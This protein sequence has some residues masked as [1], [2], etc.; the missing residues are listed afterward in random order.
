MDGVHEAEPGPE[1]GVT[2]PP[3]NHGGS[4]P[5]GLAHV[6]QSSVDRGRYG[7]MFRQLAPFAPRDA[8]LK[9]LADSM[10]PYPQPTAGEPEPAEATAGAVQPGENPD[11]PA[12]YTYLGQF[13]DHDITFD[14][15]SVLQRRNDP[16]AL[17]NYRTPRFDLDLIYGSG[18]NDQ[19]FLYDQA[20]PHK[21]LI[22]HNLDPAQE[23]VDLPRNAQGRALLGDPRNDVH[24]IISQLTLA[25]LHFHNAVVDHLR[26]RKVPD[27]DL[28]AEAQRITRWHY[29]WV[30]TEDYLQRTVGPE[31]LRRVL[32][33]DPAGGGRRAELRY[34]KWKNDPF[35]PVEFSA[36]AYRFGHSQVRST[37][38]LNENQP[39]KHILLPMLDADPLD[40][41]EGF[42]P[43]P[44]G[45]T[46]GWD[47]YFEIDG[48]QPQLSRRIDTKM[49]GPFN[50]LPPALDA[51]GRS[52]AF[53]DMVRGRALGLPSGQDVAAAM[54]L[55]RSDLGLKGKTPLWYYL[56]AEA[57]VDN[58]GV[59]LGPAGATIVA[60]VLV[61]LLAADPS[62][63]LRAAPAWTPELP[64]AKPGTFTMGDL[65]RFAGMA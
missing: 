41:L 17:V 16:D 7:R 33:V 27:A 53:V 25:F 22:G 37:Y 24:I 42:R 4:P 23:P 5:R 56:L 64:S 57:E 46:I 13:V 36:A 47:L 18:P 52:M 45:W 28:F 10:Q 31:V 26:A 35:M 54:K 15:T 44:K 51:V 58:G 63:Y 9:R 59:R 6:P 49:V 3:T 8:T 55:S 2:D 12:G 34:Y 48:S 43:L 50:R 29:Q 62:S 19:P 11:I 21:L 39:P 1:L 60:E 65:L 30:V 20:D 40:H 32:P 14:P 38:F 61:G